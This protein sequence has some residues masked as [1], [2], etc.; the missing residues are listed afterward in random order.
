M[1]R[2]RRGRRGGDCD[3]VEEV[4]DAAEPKSSTHSRA[5]LAPV[6]RY[7]CAWLVYTWGGLHRYFGNRNH[8]R[9]EHAAAVRYFGRAYAIDPTFRRARLERGVLLWRELEQPAAAL[10]EFDALL[11]KD[12]N[13]GPALLNRAMVRQNEGHYEAALAD[14]TAYLGL[15]KA[16]TTAYRQEAERTAA[17]LK[18]LIESTASD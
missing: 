15:P 11:T 14:L 10:A 17:L 3:D 9:S 2:G 1:G 16:T 5:S 18:E 7:I 6:I 4:S 12:P 13:Y 8:M